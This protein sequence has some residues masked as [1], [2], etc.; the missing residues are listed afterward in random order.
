MY[1]V[2]LHKEDILKQYIVSPFSNRMNL[3][4]WILQELR[5][6]VKQEIPILITNYYF[7]F[8]TKLKSVHE[9]DLMDNK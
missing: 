5:L 1:R 7:Y 3:F 9:F 2:K 8:K 4:S 6:Y